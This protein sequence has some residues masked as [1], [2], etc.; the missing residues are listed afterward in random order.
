MA[1]I[2]LFGAMAICFAMVYCAGMLFA[3]LLEIISWLSRKKRKEKGGFQ[4][5]I[6]LD[7]KLN[8]E[9][10]NYDDVLRIPCSNH[11]C[12]LCYRLHSRI[13]S[14]YAWLDDVR[15]RHFQT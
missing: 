6:A 15:Y 5:S 3:G 13:V 2:G 7:K 12:S 14:Y 4:P 11:A 1:D 10:G 9:G 8:N